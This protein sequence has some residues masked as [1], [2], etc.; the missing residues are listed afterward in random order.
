MFT[1]QAKKKNCSLYSCIFFLAWKENLSLKCKVS[2]KLGG[3]KV[4]EVK[5][6]NSKNVLFRS[7]SGTLDGFLPTTVNYTE[8][9]RQFI[10]LQDAQIIGYR[11]GIQAI[12][13][14][15]FQA[16]RLKNGV[17]NIC[18]LLLFSQNIF[19]KN[20]QRLTRSQSENTRQLSAKVIE[21]QLLII[22]QFIQ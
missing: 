1:V 17:L 4:R 19:T 3:P 2:N 7:D 15:L 16:K 11:I 22:L 9:C 5:L 21:Q 8:L 20:I 6:S 10:T 14:L 13:S 18:N 12:I